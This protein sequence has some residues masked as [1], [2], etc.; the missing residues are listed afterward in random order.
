M[1]T[2]YA[3]NSLFEIHIFCFD[4]GLK[5]IEAED[6]IVHYFP[7][8]KNRLKSYMIFFLKS[9]STIV[10]EKFDLIFH[11]NSNFSLLFRLLNILQ[12]MV[13]D[14]RTGDLSSDPLKL[15]FKNNLIRFN[16]I[17]YSHISVISDS[18]AK[19]LKL[20]PDKTTILPL[21]AEHQNFE[22]K[23]FS[24]IKMLY[25]GSLDN[26]NIAETIHG[27]SIYKKAHLLV[28]ISYDIVGFGNKGTEELIKN[29]IVVNEMGNY[30]KFHGRKTYAEV[31][32]FLNSC[33][34]GVVYVPQTNYYDCQP[35]TKLFESL[36]SGMPVIATETLE[37]KNVFQPGCGALCKA[38]PS[39]FSFAINYIVNNKH[40]FN[41]EE[42]K[43]R[44][45]S[46]DWQ[47]IV[48]NIW[49]PY[50]LKCLSE[51]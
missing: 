2:K 29:A 15:W 48:E 47:S 38:N 33:N 8:Y 6:A 49:T 28:D 37:N 18:L 39:S 13:L 12:P 31:G 14:I 3:N 23:E 50:I 32:H 19:K 24:S 5:K 26:R 34:V 36:L 4:Q 22:K 9:R 30:I 10:K 43:S 25:I 44:Y 7:L 40:S 20:K 41:S 42:I 16:S 46:F 17:F 45:S 35:T 27:F 51:K 21:G 11:I 1:Y